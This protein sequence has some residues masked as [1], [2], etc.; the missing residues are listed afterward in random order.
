MLSIV[1]KISYLYTFL[2]MQTRMCMH[3]H[4]IFKGSIFLKDY[5]LHFIEKKLEI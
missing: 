1:L 4:I 2:Q 5:Y 3:T